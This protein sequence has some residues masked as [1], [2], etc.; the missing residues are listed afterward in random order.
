VALWPLIDAARTL[1]HRL[2]RR[3]DQRRLLYDGRAPMNY[4]IFEPIHERLR[5]DPRIVVCLVASDAPTRA[6][7]IFAEAP[8]DTRILPLGLAALMRFDA[9]LACDLLWATLLRGS[10][11]VQMFHGVAG[12]YGYDA[13]RTSMRHWHRILFPNRRRLRH[14]VEAG[15]IDP[16][17]CAIR[18]TG[19]PKTDRLVDGSLVR[20]R[21]LTRLGLDP[22]RPTVLFAPTWSQAS[23]LV[24]HG[25]EL[26]ERLAATPYNVLLKLHD[27]SRELS[28]G[29]DWVGT[30]QPL[31]H[32]ERGRMASDA[33]I[34]P[35]LAAADVLI[36]D[37][38]SAGFEYLLLDRP[39][40]RLH[41][42]DLP[43][44]AN[45]HPDYLALFAEVSAPARNAV[46]A[47]RCVE[48]ALAHPQERA[49]ARGV[50]AADLFHEPGSATGHCV[51]ALYEVL[52]LDPLDAPTPTIGSAYV[53]AS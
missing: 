4:A 6:R 22:A 9:Y 41:A 27:R 48:H 8:A 52:E 36:T 1:D 26:V 32:P 42:P 45:I 16:G 53:V 39:I 20:D 19:L 33:D 37:H 24:L 43:R 29:T 23:S 49:V 13:P 3:P 34:C 46:D 28:P 12:K 31:L 5:R 44:V 25:R 11:R 35:Y 50:V 7:Q 21:I 30:L 40:V 14:F 18:L 2:T 10:R 47:V 38:S 51:N 15:A 17:S